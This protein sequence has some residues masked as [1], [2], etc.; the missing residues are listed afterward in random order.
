MNVGENVTKYMIG[1]LVKTCIRR[2]L[3]HTIVTVIRYA[4]LTNI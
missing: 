3:A 2:I 4:K 1:V